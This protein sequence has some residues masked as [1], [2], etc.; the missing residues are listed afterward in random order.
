MKW[1]VWFAD[2]R[3]LDSAHDEWPAGERGVLV[4]VAWDERGGRTVSWGEAFYG[5]PDTW[6]VEG[7]VSDEEFARV[8]AKAKAT[9]EPPA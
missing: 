5:R 3:I 6:A 8:L 2:G 1:C 9:L 7:R 4:V